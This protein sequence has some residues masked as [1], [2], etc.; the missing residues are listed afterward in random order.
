MSSEWNYKI[1]SF[2]FCF[3]RLRKQPKLIQT[4]TNET[5]AWRHH[6][7]FLTTRSLELATQQLFIFVALNP[8]AVELYLLFPIH[9]AS[10]RVLFQSCFQQ[11]ARRL[12]SA[13]VIHIFYLPLCMPLHS[14]THRH[15]P[16][17]SPRISLI[18]SIFHFTEVD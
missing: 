18:M 17:Q 1:I 4:P 16:F 5:L 14:S 2:I 8:T 13:Y 15:S 10:I 3:V 9:L 7:P 6:P 11:G 12:I